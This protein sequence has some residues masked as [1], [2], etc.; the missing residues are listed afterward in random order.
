MDDNVIELDDYRNQGN[1]AREVLL[2]HMESFAND[3]TELGEIADF[4]DGLL[5][6]LWVAGYKIVPVTEKTD[7]PEPPLYA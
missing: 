2:E 4:V 6:S 3:D 7:A 5:A 1:G